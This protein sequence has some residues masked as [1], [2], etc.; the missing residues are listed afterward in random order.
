MKKIIQF[1]IS[2]GDTHYIAEGVG[3]PVVTQ[4]QSLDDLTANL[5]EA[6]ELYLSGESMADIGLEREPSLLANIE[7]PLEYA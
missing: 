6:T 5:K 2:K 4:G 7:L 3:V 1:H